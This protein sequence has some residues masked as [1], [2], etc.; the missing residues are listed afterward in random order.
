MLPPFYVS[1]QHT[2]PEKIER[3][4]RKVALPVRILAV[5]DLRLLR[6]QHQIAGHEAIR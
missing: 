5:D 1:L 6:M 3:N 4:D 2:E